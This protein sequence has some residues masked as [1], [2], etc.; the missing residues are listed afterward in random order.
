MFT[1]WKKNWVGEHMFLLLK[2]DKLSIHSSDLFDC[3][4]SGMFT[5]STT[6]KCVS[7]IQAAGIN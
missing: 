4:Q 5:L 3:K 1:Y 2:V 7:L 6:N